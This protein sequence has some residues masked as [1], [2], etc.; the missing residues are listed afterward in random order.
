MA[1]V[2]SKTHAVVNRVAVALVVVI[3]LIY[4]IPIYWITTTSATAAR[5]SAA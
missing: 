5:L 3:T 1:A 4:L 2:Q